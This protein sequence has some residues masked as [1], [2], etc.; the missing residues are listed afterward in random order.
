M[1]RSESG[2]GRIKFI[3]ALLFLAAVAFVSVKVIPVY[4]RNYE[5]KDEIHGLAIQATVDR[6]AAAAVQNRV[7]VYAKDLDLPITRENVVVQVGDKV[8][9]N[10]DYTVPI[11]LKVYTWVL[12]FTPSAEN[13]QI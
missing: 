13:K 1:R 12:H 11:D 2:K 6:S 7:L 5:F 4:V 9:I 3:F 8:A 10:V